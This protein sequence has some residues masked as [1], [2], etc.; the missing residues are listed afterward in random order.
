MS[1]TIMNVKL[2][3]G[4]TDDL[5]SRPS[6]IDQTS[7]GSNPYVS[8]LFKQLHKII[9][10]LGNGAW[11]ENTS[12]IHKGTIG[13]STDHGDIQSLPEASASNKGDCYNVITSGTYSS[14]AANKGDWF[15]SNGSTWTKVSFYDVSE[16]ASQMS[17]AGVTVPE[18]THALS[19]DTATTATTATSA[20]SATTAEKLS[21]TSAIGNTTNPVYFTSSGVPSA[22]QYTIES[23]VPSNAVFTDTNTFRAV[24]VNGVQK[25]ATD[26][27]TPLDITAGS[28]V[29]LTESSGVVT[30][31]ATDTTYSSEPASS[32]GSTVSLVTT[33][34]KYT[35]NNMVSNIEFNSSTGVLSKTKSGSTSTLFTVEDSAINGDMNPITSNAVYDIVGNI[36]TILESVL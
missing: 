11:V 16:I 15:I 23:S 31:G 4:Y 17:S 21:N 8:T 29:T 27:T 10:G 7:S 9:S 26:S 19:A 32:G 33:G 28:N 30:I 24:K 25:L 13:S 22:I 5:A 12:L 2:K 3:V 14:Q 1:E 6:N 20:G 34:E 36:N 18:A 35:W